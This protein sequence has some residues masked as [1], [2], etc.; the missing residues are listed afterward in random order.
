MQWDLDLACWL[1]GF[2]PL[3]WE[4]TRVS[5]QRV[6]FLIIHM[7]WVLVSF[8]SPWYFPEK[9]GNICL[10]F[11]HVSFNIQWILL[12]LTFFVELSFELSNPYSFIYSDIIIHLFIR[13]LIGLV[14]CLTFLSCLAI[15]IS[16]LFIRYFFAY[17]FELFSCLIYLFI[18]CYLFL[19]NCANSV[20]CAV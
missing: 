12:V 5:F 9:S 11:R 18:S 19:L 6:S 15:R 14:F 8:I 7:S 4:K 20:L 3:Q 13:I 2:G 16:S 17:L 10:F 1:Y